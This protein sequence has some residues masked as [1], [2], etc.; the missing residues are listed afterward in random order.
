VENALAR[1]GDA[2]LKKPVCIA[3]IEELVARLLK[4]GV[5][6]SPLLRVVRG[7]IDSSG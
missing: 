4:T 1:C 2:Y 3:D 5:R 6:K 7:E